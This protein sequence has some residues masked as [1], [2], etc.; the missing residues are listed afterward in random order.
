MGPIQDTYLRFESAGDQYVGRVVSGLP[1]SSSQFAAMPPEFGTVEDGEIAFD[2]FPHLP[3]HMNCVVKYLSASLLK[4]ID[5]F[6]TIIPSN[7]AFL[8][9]SFMSNIS[10]HTGIKNRIKIRYA[11][12]DEVTVEV[13]NPTMIDQENASMLVGLNSIP[14]SHNNN[15][16]PIITNTLVSD[17]G[18]RIKKA[19]GIPVHVL[20][21]AEMKKV[22]LQQKDMISDLRSVVSSELDKREIGSAPYQLQE[23][24]EKLMNN[25]QESITKKLEDA[26]PSDP[27]KSTH[28]NSTT[29]NMGEKGT[30]FNWNGKWRRVPV[31]FVFPLNMGLQSA[32]NKYFYGDPNK[33]IGPF[34]NIQGPDLN[35]KYNKY[36][37]DHVHS[38]KR[39]MDFMVVE[40]KRLNCWFE[41]PNNDQLKLMYNKASPKVFGLCKSQRAEAFKWSTLSRK[42]FNAAKNNKSNQ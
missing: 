10:K 36:G 6:I 13:V 1:L 26:L 35:V 39:L 9:T 42:V 15:S 30:L 7:H 29:I 2:L 21:L 24:V 34:R 4:A 12:E 27:S 17:G 16:D 40:C 25:F 20:L 8:Q 14:P 37:R 3:Q 32:F 38:F 19:T 18:D 11:W 23:R 28:V 5:Y 41:N 31:D 22:I 33:K